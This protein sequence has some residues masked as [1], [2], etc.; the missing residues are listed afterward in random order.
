MLRLQ[1]FLEKPIQEQQDLQNIDYF[2]WNGRE[3]LNDDLNLFYEDL[4]GSVKRKMILKLQKLLKDFDYWYSMSSDSRAYRKGKEQQ[5]EIEDLVNQLGKD[6]KKIYKKYIAT[7]ESMN[8][9]DRL[10]INLSLSGE[11]LHMVLND[12]QDSEYKNKKD[13]EKDKRTKKEKDEDDELVNVKPKI[14]E[15]IDYM[16]PRNWFS[17]MSGVKATGSLNRCD[18]DKKQKG[19][20]TSYMSDGG[21]L[22]FNTPEVHIPKPSKLRSIDAKYY[23]RNS[24][25]GRTYKG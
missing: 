25:Y 20:V 10:D 6:G 19:N 15:T 16:N 11:T 22:S 17:E 18:T 23:E 1:S 24:K 21:N 12:I 13:G 14:K 7:K 3:R 2:K 4:S 8:E 9:E 5:S